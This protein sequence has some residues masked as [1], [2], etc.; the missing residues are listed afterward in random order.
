MH[1]LNSAVFSSFVILLATTS[2]SQPDY[3]SESGLSKFISEGD[4]FSKTI[5][6][7]QT[8]IKITYKPTDLLVAQELR[9][10]KDPSSQQ[11][12]EVRNKYGSHY[13]FII[14]F[15]YNDAEVLNP[16]AVGQGHFS[17]LLQTMSFRMGEVIN[18]TTS[19][20]DTI[21]VADYIYNRTFGLSRS[22]DLLFVFDKE[23]AKGREWIQIN[24][25]EFGLGVGKQSVQ[26]QVNDLE[27][28][29]KIYKL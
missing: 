9:S 17:T 13:Y 4:K 23:K 22:T 29:P 26:F 21:P 20:N 10:V 27:T 19:A 5:S 28:T 15:S 25:D 12:S 2:C 3:L 14:S 6:A 24:L 8:E 7:N 11:I 18:L 1:F 16:S